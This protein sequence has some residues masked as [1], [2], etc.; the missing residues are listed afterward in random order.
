MKIK[1]VPVLCTG[2]T[3]KRI[4]DFC[5]TFAWVPSLYLSHINPF[6][7]HL[8]SFLV[9]FHKWILLVIMFDSTLSNFNCNYIIIGWII[10]CFR[11]VTQ[12]NITFII[13]RHAR[14]RSVA[15]STSSVFWMLSSSYQQHG[16]I[17]NFGCTVVIMGDSNCQDLHVTLLQ[18]LMVMGYH[19]NKIQI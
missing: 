12:T 13:L 15:L 3:R 14:A 9:G 18:A 2:P 4:S 6:Q 5:L 8:C 16:I 1:I 19:L 7:R 11:Q 10:G 17:G